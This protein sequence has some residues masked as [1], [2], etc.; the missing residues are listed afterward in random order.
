MPKLITALLQ[1]GR[2]DQ[3]EAQCRQAL[4]VKPGQTD[5][6]FL[7]ARSLAAQ[8]QLGESL[9]ILEKALSR[10]PKTIPGWIMAGTLAD[11]LQLPEQSAKAWSQVARLAPS[12]AAWF[13]LGNAQRHLGKQAKA[14]ESYGKAHQLDL[15]DGV[16][17][18]ALIARRQALCQWDDLETLVQ[19]LKTMIDGGKPG[20]QPFRLLALEMGAEHHFKAARQITSSFPTGPR[21]PITKKQRITLG[22]LS[23]NFNCHAVAWLSA[24]VF[25]LHNR[26]DFEILGFSTGYDDRSPVRQRLEKAFDGFH[27]LEGASDEAVAQAIKQAKVDILIDL[28]GHT[29]GGRL[30]VLALRPAPVQVSW[31]GYPGT[32]G[33][34]FVD[35]VIGDQWVLPLEAQPFYT[36]KI[37]RLPHSY[38]CNDRKR[39]LP[40]SLG[41]AAYGL[42]ERAIVLACFNAPY[43]YGRAV[44]DVW[45]E[46][47]QACPQTVLWLMGDE[48]ETEQALYARAKTFGIDKG[49]LLFAAHIP[50]EQHLARYGVVDLMLDNLPYNAH[51]TGS[52]ALW[53]GCPVLT[54]TG[55]TFAARVGASLL[56]AVGLPELITHNLADYKAL[57][58]ELIANPDRLQNYRLQLENGRAT[59]PLFDTP[60]FVRDLEQAYKTIIEHPI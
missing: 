20:I 25:E 38:Q 4:K 14:A 8:G 24:E 11:Q 10:S 29:R 53:M 33:A 52:D 19:R 36:E 5:I 17:L 48:A 54:C 43:K 26:Q 32:T 16:I 9:K 37:V 12:S 35:Y 7:L 44:F 50:L 13:N 2:P 3:A 22:Y 49:R 18:S 23:A 58:L 46:L 31:L 56:S 40:P 60:A 6:M 41:R 57:A 21:P 47:L 51:T 28:T 15:E 42:P 1:A 34:D 45:M 27:Q 30:G 59:H 55:D 39:P